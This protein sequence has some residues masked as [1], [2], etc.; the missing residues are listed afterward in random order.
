MI[1]S[2]G[3]YDPAP[4]QGANDALWAGLRDRLRAAG[5]AAPEALT[6]GPGAY[7]PAWE[8]PGL[9]FSQTCGLPYRARLHGRVTLVA[10][11]DHGLEGCPPGHYRSLYLVRGDDPRRAVEAFDGALLAFNDGLSQSGWAAPQADAAAR[12]IAFRT[13]PQTGAHAAS[14]A[15]VA[16]GRAEIAAVD[17]VTWAILTEQGL[18]PAGLRVAG[19]TVPTPAL[20]YIAGPGADADAVADALE[21][22]IAALPAATRAA[23]HL[24]GIVRLPAAAWLALPL[25]VPPESGG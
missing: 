6:R 12:G 8:D 15:A 17:A 11:P 3:M 13:G 22:A 25:P 7:W 24:R 18:A 16:E 1:A 5:I 21:G 2:L 4:L 10:A 20:P 19:A 9:V 23:L 14:A